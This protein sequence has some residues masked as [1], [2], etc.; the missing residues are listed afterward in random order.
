MKPVYIIL[1]VVIG[2]VT[3]I[4]ISTTGNVSEYA[5]F[6]EA[7]TYAEKGDTRA[8][9]VVGTLIRNPEGKVTEVFYDPILDPNRL[10]FIME[11]T[12][13]VRERVVYFQPMPQDFERSEKLV[14]IGRYHKEG[15]F[16]VEKILMKCPSKYENESPKIQTSLAE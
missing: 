6:S 11:D 3:A 9:H 13:K 15:R 16:R 12:L 2:I 10:E 5:G 14:V 7:K 4:I 1:L 8:V